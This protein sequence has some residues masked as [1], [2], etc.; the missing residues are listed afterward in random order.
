MRW[1]TFALI[2]ALFL[3]TA[4]EDD[5]IVGPGGEDDNGGGSYGVIHFNTP[6]VAPL[7]SA[8]VEFVR[9]PEPARNDNPKRF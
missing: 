8:S 2:S 7:D 6:P 3:V 9:P 1:K 4:C 5:P